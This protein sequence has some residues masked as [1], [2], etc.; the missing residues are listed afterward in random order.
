MPLQRGGI[1]LAST[2]LG[3]AL[4]SGCGGVISTTYDHCT[5]QQTVRLTAVPDGLTRV[6]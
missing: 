2:F 4:L 3:M 5:G 1:V 6:G